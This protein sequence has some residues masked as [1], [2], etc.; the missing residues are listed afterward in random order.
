MLNTKQKKQLKSMGNTLRPL[1]NVGK[2][3]ISINLIGTLEDS[4]RAHELVKISV[5]KSCSIPVMECALDIVSMTHSE[6]VQV[7]GKSILIYKASDKKKI[8][9]V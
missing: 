4:L 8:Q 2:D 3:G 7:I 1:F 6:L 9:L 5:L